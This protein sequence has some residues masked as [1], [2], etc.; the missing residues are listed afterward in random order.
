MMTMM[1]P[2]EISLMKGHWGHLLTVVP[3]DQQL[4]VAALLQNQ[5]RLIS[6]HRMEFYE[7]RKNDFMAARLKRTVQQEQLDLWHERNPHC[8][9]VLL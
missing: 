9:G 4:E 7:K 6:E 5:Q 2:E 1:T 8:V 3:E